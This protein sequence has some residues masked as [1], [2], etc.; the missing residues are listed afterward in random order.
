ME[1]IPDQQQREAQDV[2]YFDDVTS[3]EGWQGYATKKSIEDLKAEVIAAIGRMDGLVTG[4][5]QGVY[6][7]GGKERGGY[8][9]HYVVEH[10]DGTTVQGRLD[11]AA[12][13]VKDTPRS[14]RSFE[15]RKIKSL[16]MAL[17]MVRMSL[18]GKWFL[19]QLSPGYVPL[20]PWMLVAGG[21]TVTQLWSERGETNNLLPAGNG[22]FIEG[23]YKESDQ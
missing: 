18:N 21:K 16:K 14:R 22:E 23:E 8:Q 5:V 15:T 10:S 13:P 4:F 17:Y 1:F 7:I 11:V 12:L 2:P 6:H 19:Q 9:I 20:M 3:E